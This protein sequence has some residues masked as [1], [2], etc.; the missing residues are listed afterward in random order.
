MS[1]LW[2]MVRER[3]AWG[4]AVHGAAKRRTRIR[5]ETTVKTRYGSHRLIYVV[6]GNLPR[7]GTYHCESANLE[8]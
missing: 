7:P 4:A 6:A 2:E 3:E 5:D 1:K 8:D